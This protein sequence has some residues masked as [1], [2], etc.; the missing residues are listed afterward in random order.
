[1]RKL[2][3][4]LV[5]GT[6]IVVYLA[7]C[8]SDSG[9]TQPN[10]TCSGTPFTVAALTGRVIA[11]ADLPCLSIPADGGTYLV[12][13]Q[14][15]TATVAVNPVDFTLSAG[16]PGAS[17]NRI[18]SASRQAPPFSAGASPDLSQ[19]Q[20]SLESALRRREREVAAAARSGAGTGPLASRVHTDAA[21]PPVGT[22]ASF[23]VLSSF[24]NGSQYTTDT[25]VLKYSGTHL[26]IYVSKNAPAGGFSDGQLAAFGNTFDLDL[27][28]IDVATF[29]QPTDIDANGRVIVLLSP[30]INK[31]TKASDCT[32]LGY[33]AGFFNAVDLLPAQYP[34]KSNGAEIF[35]SLVPDPNATLSCT[36]T[37]DAV[38][39]LTPS[40]FI[41]EFQHMISFGQHAIL[42]NGNEEDPWLNEGLSHI[43]EELGSR[44]YENRFPPPTGRTDP[45]QA[46]PDSSQG[47]IT[48]DL[49]N[50]FHYLLNTAST[51]SSDKA[52]VSNWGDGDGTLVQRG[53]VWLFLR[54]LGDQ[55]DSTVYGRLDQT[56]QTGVPNLE[57]ASGQL[58]PTLFGEFS[59]ALYVD[60]LPGIPR[61]SIPPEL[62]FTS[63]NLRALYGKQHERNPSVFSQAFPIEALA[64]QPGTARMESMHPGTMDFFVLT[65]PS[66]GSP[67]GLS[68][69]PATGTFA[70]SLGAQVSVF[71][72]PSAAACPLSIPNN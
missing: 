38:E 69:A 29:G 72:C 26:L 41:H 56:D 5:L 20:R 8:S 23:H 62:R 4:S 3:P 57:T 39:Q 60:S 28:T 50:S 6:G 59:L 44:Y 71:H 43:A 24:T 51:D 37:L 10:G 36:H 65:A 7:A 68:F 18:V 17:A 46:F 1:M 19:M 58:F 61:S 35:Y 64:L 32:T 2:L 67:L 14:F 45:D 16:V 66:S 15:A 34:G 30:I 55:Q 40:T 49:Y 27:Y 48:G 13:P 21:P 22:S 52:S 31:L 12:V 25:A 9:P 33:I 11:E 53:A 63:R 70:G 47:F 42:R 54:W